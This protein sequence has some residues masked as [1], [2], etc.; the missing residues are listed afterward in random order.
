MQSDFRQGRVCEVRMINS[1]LKIVFVDWYKTLSSSKFFV[2]KKDP[3]PE[4]CKI[5]RHRTFVENEP[6]LVP[7]KSGKIF[8]QDILNAISRN[9]KEYDAFY[10]LL[11]A[12]CENMEFDSDAFLPKIER[13]RSKGV[14]V[15]VATD[16]FDVFCDY[17]VPSLRLHELFDD[18]VSSHQVGYVKSDVRNGRLKF[19]EDTLKK[20]RLGYENA[21]MLDDQLEVVNACNQNGLSAMRIERPQDLEKALEKL[22][23][24]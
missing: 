9:R 5:C 6:L 22:A 21:V 23:A 15:V 12:S 18:V 4:L 14:K 8:K 3:Q 2:N 19:F 20:Y 17:S 24:S 16:N 11:K 1:K 7:W 10:S 13:L